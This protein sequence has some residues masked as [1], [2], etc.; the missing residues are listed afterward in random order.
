MSWT[1]SST[2]G[3][4]GRTEKRFCIE[5][6]SH[7]FWVTPAYARMHFSFVALVYVETISPI[8]DESIYETPDQSSIIFFAPSERTFETASLKATEP[9]PMV[10]F[11]LKLRTTTPSTVLSSIF[12]SAMTSILISY[13]Y[14]LE[15]CRKCSR[16][17]RDNP[18]ELA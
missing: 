7:T 6:R 2:E 4:E 5:A 17:F 15:A 3:Y 13:A 10:G 14:R 18:K 12:S 11:P 8:P 16:L 1:A 9:S